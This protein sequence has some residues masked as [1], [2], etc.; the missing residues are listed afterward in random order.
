MALASTLE[1]SVHRKGTTR[2]INA[3]PTVITLTP[4]G[5]E[6]VDGTYKAGVGADREAQRFKIIWGGESGIVRK[7]PDTVYRFDFILLGEYNA[8]VAIGDTFSIGDN[9]YIVE[10]VFPYNDYEVKAGGVSHG[11]NPGNT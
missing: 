5:G 7:T 11:A 9:K 1:K 8:I 6:V 4:T 10:Y 2:F 3:D